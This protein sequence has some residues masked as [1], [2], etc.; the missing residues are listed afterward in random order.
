MRNSVQHLINQTLKQVQETSSGCPGYEGGKR[1]GALEL[2]DLR[3]LAGCSNAFHDVL[4]AAG[5][6]LLYALCSAQCLLILQFG[7]SGPNGIFDK[8]HFI[9]DI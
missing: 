9:M 4:P 5:S 8:P 2:I 1:N 3:G 6:A 7:E